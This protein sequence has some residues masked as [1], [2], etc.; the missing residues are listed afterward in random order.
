MNGRWRAVAPDVLNWCE[1][2]GQWL[3]HDAGS[4]RLHLL[5]DLTAAV[6]SILEAASA[7]VD[8][9]AQRLS[10]AS[11]QRL[12]GVAVAGVI[13]NLCHVDLVEPVCP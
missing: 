1:I 11:G 12:D 7:S 2:D 8:E 13:R 5:D 10:E 9:I 3:L 4:A 6:L